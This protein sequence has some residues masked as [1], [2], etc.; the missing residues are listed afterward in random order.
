MIALVGSTGIPDIVDMD[1][2]NFDESMIN[3]LRNND[4]AI[5]LFTAIDDKYGCYYCQNLWLE[6][7]EVHSAYTQTKDR[8]KNLIFVRVDYGASRK[9]F[10]SVK[11]KCCLNMFSD[12]ELNEC[13]KPKNYAI[14]FA[15]WFTL[16]LQI[17]SVPRIYHIGQ[18]G[19]ASS[20]PEDIFSFDAKVGFSANLIADFVNHRANTK[21]P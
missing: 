2:S 14:L 16:Q 5:V 4:A 1:D 13:D 8:G 9:V 18:E 11:Q 7:Q 10:K 6:F 21:V 12:N 19:I 17:K 20:G 15:R 3:A